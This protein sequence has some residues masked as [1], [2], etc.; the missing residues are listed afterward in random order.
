MGCIIKIGNQSVS[1]TDFLN[2]LNKIISVNKLFEENPKFSSQIY[3]ALGFKEKYKNI[4]RGNIIN[5]LKEI[6]TPHLKEFADLF[7]QSNINIPLYYSKAQEYTYVIPDNTIIISKNSYGVIKHKSIIHE[8]L[9]AG[10]SNKLLFDSDFKNQVNTIIRDIKET[11]QQGRIAFAYEL[12]SADEFISGLSEKSFVDYLK[13]AGLYDKVFS[14][15]K[16]NI[17]FEQGFKITSEQKQQ[18]QQLYS[19]YLDSIKSNVILPTDRIVFGHPTIGKSFLKNQGEDKFI[20]LDDDYA[21]EINNK[22][23]EIADKYNVTTYQVKDGGTQNWN[24]EYNQ[25]MQEMFN[26]AKQRAISENKTLFTSNTNLLKN[27]VESF[28]KVINLTDK[29]FERRIQERGAKYDVKKWKSQINEAISKFPTNKVINTN[30]YL[31]DLFLGSKQDIEGFKQFVNKNTTQV[32][33]KNIKGENI[34]SKGSEFAKKL[35]N[36]GNSVGLTYKGKEYVNSEHAYQTW[37]SGEFNQAGYNLKG[38]KVRGG[39]IGDTFSIMTD[40]LTEKLKQHPD[41][42]QGINER[43]GLEYLQKSTHNVIGDKFWESTGQNKF[44]EALIQAYKNISQVVD[45]GIDTN[46]KKLAKETNIGDI[47]YD[48]VGN[49]VQRISLDDYRQ[50]SK[51]PESTSGVKVK[52]LKELVEIAVPNANPKLSPTT[53]KELIDVKENKV[54]TLFENSKITQELKPNIENNND[55]PNEEN[56]TEKNNDC[57]I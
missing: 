37:K 43:G 27:N 39:K 4:E 36:V 23:K 14:L 52:I 8:L 2:H 7:I 56:W 28:D 29:E 33:D 5:E 50:Y 42:A 30:K 12:E 45:N 25:I 9:H 6:T 18:A 48:S 3:E 47:F 34:T 31:S 57:G 19:Q 41:L 10:T 53:K 17:S 13:K 44:I 15:V 40:I 49:L 11:D 1:E 22:V 24:N 54:N 32:V 35:T 21:T 46:R 38:G 20:S 55:S 26:V 51:I 16:D